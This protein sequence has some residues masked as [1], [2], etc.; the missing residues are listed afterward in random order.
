M[1][2]QSIE[3]WQHAHVFIGAAYRRNERKTWAVVAL[4]SAM[5]L[6]EIL[7]GVLFGS[8]ALIADGLH[9]ST[10]AGAPLIAALADLLARL[11]GRSAPRLRHR[12]R[13]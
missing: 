6:G 5:M 4:A 8:V 13:P 7:G 9:M 3:S 12:V 10:H 1:Q 2:T 11:C